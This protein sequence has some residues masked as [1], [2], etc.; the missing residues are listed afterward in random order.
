M[1]NRL[2]AATMVTDFLEDISVQREL[3]LTVQK[4]LLSK[5]YSIGLDTWGMPIQNP[6]MFMPD[7]FDRLKALITLI[8]LGFEDQITLGNDFSSK[9]EWRA[10]GG[11]GCTRFADF[12]GMMMELLG[13][14]DQYHKLVYENPMRIMQF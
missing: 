13:R 6:N 14:E 11:S 7:D 4:K 5:G 2:I 10:Y 9:I 8:D 12:G 3:D 1:D